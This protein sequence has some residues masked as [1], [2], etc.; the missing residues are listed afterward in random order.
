MTNIQSSWPN[1]LV[2]G[3][4]VIISFGTH[5]EILKLTCFVQKTLRDKSNKY[6]NMA[7]TLKIIN[8]NLGADKPHYLVL[9][10]R[11][12]GLYGRIL[13]EVVRTNRSGEVFTEDRGQESP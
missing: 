5:R 10:N 11:A 7:T 9:I 12:G 1:K 4:R 6:R 2:Y 8:F 3:F 13:T